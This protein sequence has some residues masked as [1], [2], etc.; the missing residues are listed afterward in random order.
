MQDR[1]G[2]KD[3]PNNKGSF[4][5]KCKGK[6]NEPGFDGFE[7]TVSHSQSLSSNILKNRLQRE[8]KIHVLQITYG[9]RLKITKLLLRFFVKISKNSKVLLSGSS[10]TLNSMLYRLSVNRV[11]KILREFSHRR[12]LSNRS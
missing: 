10:K 7:K 6:N 11:L 5:V 8:A 2:G 1:E 12:L 4:K 9:N 3:G